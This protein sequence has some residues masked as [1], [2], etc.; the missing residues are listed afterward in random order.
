MDILTFL[1]LY[2]TPIFTALA[3]LALVVYAIIKK[4][5]PTQDVISKF[6]KISSDVLQGL[7]YIF[8]SIHYDPKV[9]NSKLKKPLI[10]KTP[11][12]IKEEILK[13]TKEE[14]TEKINQIIKEEIGRQKL[15]IA[16]KT[17]EESKHL[18]IPK[19]I[20]KEFGGLP[21]F[22]QFAYNMLKHTFK[23]K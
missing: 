21:A 16:I 14:S 2:G 3:V 4:V 5:M 12:I 10:L 8:E 18:N 19:Q 11:E 6:L 22:V 17:V 13:Q 9:L 23:K 7:I 1:Q 20:I 15:E